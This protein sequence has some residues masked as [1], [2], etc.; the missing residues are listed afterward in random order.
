MALFNFGKK[1]ANTAPVTGIESIKVLGGGCKSCHTLL[2][3]TQQAAKNL[4][5]RV[6]TE[7]ITDMEKVMSYGVMQMP[8]LVVNE[9]VMSYG[10]VLTA[11]QAE[12]LIR[13]A[14]K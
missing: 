3:N 11:A 14:G 10:K 4:A 13:K 6:N 7:Y 2:L 1:Q 8:L 9:K 5:L 12:E